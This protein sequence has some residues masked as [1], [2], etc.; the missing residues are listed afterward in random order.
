MRWIWLGFLRL[1]EEIRKDPKAVLLAFLL[2]VM[3]AIGYGWWTR[4]SDA[5]IE[6]DNH[7]NYLLAQITEC[8]EDKKKIIKSLDEL[9]IRMNRQDSIIIV[10]NTM[11]TLLKKK[12]E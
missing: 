9:V 8:Q 11:L 12:I 1:L 2:I 7:T 3:V 10:Q 6:H 4:E 5:S